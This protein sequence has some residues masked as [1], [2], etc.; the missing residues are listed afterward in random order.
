MK[1]I[2]FIFVSLLG[3]VASIIEIKNDFIS[4]HIVSSDVLMLIMVLLFV[5]IL[6][7][8]FHLTRDKKDPEERASKM[9]T[10]DICKNPKLVIEKYN[11]LKENYNEVLLSRNQLKA[12][13]NL[14]KM[15]CNE[16][17][18]ILDSACVNIDNS[19]QV[20]DIFKTQ[21]H[22]QR[23]FVKEL[24]QLLITYDRNYSVFLKREE[25]LTAK[26]EQ[27]LAS[28]G[29]LLTRHLHENKSW[30]NNYQEFRHDKILR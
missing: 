17:Q 19:N 29:I 11:T 1:S 28:Y 20:I 24:I 25:S 26:Y 5:M 4:S 7:L 14:Y 21:I 10:L 30:L 12:I 23:S 15:R 2:P 8:L 16:S 22:E 3:V 9:S 27:L 18:K 6:G 13:I